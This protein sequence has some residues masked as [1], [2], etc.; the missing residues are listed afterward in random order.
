[1]IWR[2]MNRGTYRGD[3][4]EAA[5]GSRAEPL[6]L[7]LERTAPMRLELRTALDGTIPE[8]LE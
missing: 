5:T 6:L 7:D 4:T 1:M 2:S 8:F 3:W